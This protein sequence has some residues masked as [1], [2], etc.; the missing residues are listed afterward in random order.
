[1]SDPIADMLTRIRNGLSA[2]KRQ[3]AMPASKVKQAIAAVLK[4]EG[5]ISDFAVETGDNNKSELVIALK[6]Y[7]G[8]P[9]IEEIDRISKPGRR[10][11]KNAADIPLVRGGLGVAIVSTSKGIMT[12]KAARNAGTGGEVVCTVF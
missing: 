4:D 10:V 3:I 6:Y 7:Q 8:Q 11:Y 5:Y 1:M 2:S 12:G 9:V